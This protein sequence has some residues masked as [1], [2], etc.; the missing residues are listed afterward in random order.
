MVSMKKCE[1]PAKK[2]ESTRPI[3]TILEIGDYFVAA[4]KI[5]AISSIYPELES[6]TMAID[7]ILEGGTVLTITD[8]KNGMVRKQLIDMWRECRK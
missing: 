4:S 8:I 1:K 3:E 2:N 5:V 7:L 6:A